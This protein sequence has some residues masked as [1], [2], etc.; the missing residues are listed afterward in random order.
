MTVRTFAMEIGYAAVGF[1]H[2]TVCNLERVFAYNIGDSSFVE[3]IE[4]AVHRAFGDIYGNESIKGCIKGSVIN[5]SDGY[6]YK[7]Y[8]EKDFSERN[9]LE[10][11]EKDSSE[12][13]GS[14]G[15]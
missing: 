5:C 3:A 14:A 12:D 11:S 1:F 2:Y 7:I 10:I 8:C 13:I 6:N 15:C 4:D 9:M